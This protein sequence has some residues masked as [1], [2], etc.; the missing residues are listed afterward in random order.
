ML[1]P[2]SRSELLHAASGGRIWRWCRRVATT[3][4]GVASI[5]TSPPTGSMPTAGGTR[6][7][8]RAS[9]TPSR[10]RSVCAPARRSTTVWPCAPDDGLR[11]GL[12][13]GG[14]VL[15][16]PF[17]PGDRPAVRAFLEGLSPESRRLR[18]FAPQPLVADRL[19]RD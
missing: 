16:R 18:F 13:G 5:P 9:C 3:F 19:V 15:L 4:S 7:C 2:S 8:S 6:S 17:H 12:A 14:A 1:P 10:R 11:V